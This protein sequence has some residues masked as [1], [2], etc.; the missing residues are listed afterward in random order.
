MRL[1]LQLI[2]PVLLYYII[3]YYII[4]LLTLRKELALQLPVSRALMFYT[5]ILFDVLC[6]ICRFRE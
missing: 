1:T 6:Y 4:L 3:L 5:V 2:S